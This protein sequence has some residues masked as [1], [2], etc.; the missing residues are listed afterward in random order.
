MVSFL[1]NLTCIWLANVDVLDRHAG[2]ITTV[3]TI[4]I[5]AFTIALAISTKRL[6]REA[7]N[8]GITATLATRA[9]VA[10]QIPI[11]ALVEYKFALA[12][13]DGNP[14]VDPVPP[15]I[16][17]FNSRPVI[18]FQNTGPTRIVLRYYA[19]KWQIAAELTGEPYFGGMTPASLVLKAGDTHAIT[20]DQPLTYTTAE[21]SG[22][23]D[24]SL[25]VWSYGFIIYYDF[26]D[27]RH[28]MAVCAKWDIERG[29]VIVDRENYSYQK[30]EKNY[31]KSTS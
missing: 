20:T 27:E 5:A 11:V 23:K 3:A 16:P 10:S 2:A 6:W 24:G 4:V 19:I 29:F 18:V 14:A 22:V 15:G 17:P 21:L 9:A 12:S 1:D 30:H 25:R 26:L 13:I 31:T 7:K 28:D 8:S